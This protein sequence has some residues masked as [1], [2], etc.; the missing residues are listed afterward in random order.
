[1]RLDQ[2]RGAPDAW[3]EEGER[4]Q[5]SPLQPWERLKESGAIRGL[6]GLA[7]A[8]GAVV[9]IIGFAGS[10][11][12]VH[13]LAQ[14]VGF[15]WFAYVLPVG[16]DA[17]IVVL[18]ALD[19]VG[20][21]LRMGWAPLRYV[22]WLLTVATIAF[23]AASGLQEGAP[24]WRDI[25]TSSMHG[26]MPVLF[27][28]AVEWARHVVGRIADIEADRH[29]EG[30]RLRRWLLAP[31]P[32]F[33]LWRR[34]T[35]WELRTY[36]EAIATEQARLVYRAQLQAKFGRM[37]R[38][39]APL[40]LRMPLRLANFGV[41]LWLTGPPALK[42]AGIDFDSALLSPTR[43]RALPV[44]QSAGEAAAELDGAEWEDAVTA[45]VEALPLET[46]AA[47]EPTDQA[48]PAPV[49]LPDPASAQQF[50]PAPAVPQS[51]LPGP[52]APPAETFTLASFH[53]LAEPQPQ[54]YEPVQPGPPTE[55]FAPAAFQA[56]AVPEP[57]TAAWSYT[58][59]SPLTPVTE[60]VEEPEL[61]QP[62]Q[63]TWNQP[64]VGQAFGPEPVAPEAMPAG[65]SLE[66]TFPKVSAPARR[67]APVRVQ[68][69]VEDTTEDGEEPTVPAARKTSGGETRRQIRGLLAEMPPEQRELSQREVARKLIQ[70]EGPLDLKEDAVRRHLRVIAGEDSAPKG[71]ELPAQQEDP[72][73]I[74]EQP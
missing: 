24:V 1:M 53:A 23:N 13:K 43:L 10:Y 36:D 57:E 20:T 5:T 62:V 71:P 26:V 68:A 18:L 66:E 40:A 47:V 7:V 28:I 49:E 42:R 55:T 12:A 50:P 3:S 56:P 63:Q 44:G 15:G 35:L 45:A 31:W 70:P 29:M 51:H 64:T 27:V 61:V 73:A 65:G 25:L 48:A 46:A 54:A 11:D 21:W 19:V 32:T 58:P 69:L 16:I 30:V 52:Y 22:A 33:R 14:R 6:V 34:M 38:R 60:P 4:G 17:G 59:A 67:A 2:D 8:G 72:G 41:P 9:A 74:E 39:K 37:W